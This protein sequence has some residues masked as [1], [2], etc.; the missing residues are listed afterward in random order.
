VNGHPARIGSIDSMSWNGT[1]PP[2][3]AGTRRIAVK[4]HNGRIQD[5]RSY[6]AD[7]RRT[8]GWAAPQSHGPRP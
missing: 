7:P 2:G 1:S 6:G 4:G 3:L 5:E 8:K